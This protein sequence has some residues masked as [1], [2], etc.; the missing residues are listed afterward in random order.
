MFNL[1]LFDKMLLFECFN[2]INLLG[3]S[4]FTEKDLAIGACPND[5]DQIEI[6]NY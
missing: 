1:V 5:F 3:I 4:L 2:S 6:V